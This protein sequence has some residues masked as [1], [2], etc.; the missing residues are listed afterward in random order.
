MSIINM[1]QKG[2][3]PNAKPVSG[4]P[5]IYTYASHEGLCLFERERNMHDD[6]DFFMTVWNEAR[7]EPEELMFATTRGWSYP[8]MASHVDATPE[9][10]AKYE[11]WKARKDTEARALHRKNKAIILRTLRRDIRDKI[12]TGDRYLRAIK[13]RKL[14]GAEKLERLVTFMGRKPRG[15]WGKDVQAQI[16]RWFTEANP[17]YNT[18]LSPRQWPYVK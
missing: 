8:C 9:I 16:R 15:K 17:K 4:H 1:C 11:A 10:R 13:L 12:G 14:I 6:S 18:P 2:E 5:D 7:G 3:H